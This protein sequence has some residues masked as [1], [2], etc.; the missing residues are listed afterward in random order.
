MEL[1]EICRNAKEA[2]AQVAILGTNEKNE[3]LCAVAEALVAHAGE[4]IAAN[5]KDLENGRNNHMPDG[6]LDR[7]LL[8]ESRIAQIA[9]GLQKVAELEDPIGEV[10][11]MKQ[12][13]N[14]LRI[15]QKRVPLGVVGMIYEARP[16]VTVDAFGL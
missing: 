16:N 6:M 9:D 12:R 8:N 10:I 14:G 13:P 2:S 4:I 3:A 7:L 5:E 11:S 1:T 15:G